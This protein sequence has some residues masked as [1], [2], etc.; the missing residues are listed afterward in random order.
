MVES[1]STDS[2]SDPFETI[3]QNATWSKLV[4]GSQGG[5]KLTQEQVT[6]A[7]RILGNHPV[8]S[9]PLSDDP[10][11]ERTASDTPSDPGRETTGVESSPYLPPGEGDDII[12]DAPPDIPVSDSSQREGGIIGGADVDPFSESHQQNSS[13]V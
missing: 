8:E 7:M 9:P 4:Q 2:S 3:R 13:D 1:K 10:P 6:Q 5:G 12:S 11:D